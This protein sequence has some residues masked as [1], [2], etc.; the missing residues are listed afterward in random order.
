MPHPGCTA[1]RQGRRQVLRKQ[2]EKAYGAVWCGT[3]L[4][5]GVVRGVLDSECKHPV[6][7]PDSVPL[8]RTSHSTCMAYASTA[9]LIA[10]PYAISAY[11][12]V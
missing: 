1:S 6:P 7:V 8:Y 4:A 2:T 5:Y 11:G 9:H 3:A 10:H 12:A